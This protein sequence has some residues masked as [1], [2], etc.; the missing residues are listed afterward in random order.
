VI[1]PRTVHEKTE[2]LWRREI[3]AGKEHIVF[4]KSTEKRA[5]YQAFGLGAM[6][7]RH[8]GLGWHYEPMQEQTESTPAR[9]HG[10]SGH[11]LAEI[12]LTLISRLRGEDIRCL[13]GGLRWEEEVSSTSTGDQMKGAP[14]QRANSVLR[15]KVEWSSPLKR[16]GGHKSRAEMHSS[17]KSWRWSGRTPATHSSTN[18][19]L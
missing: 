7:P 14:A 15:G 5:Q 19:S 18:T 8:C 4:K 1:D 3:H 16:K 10:G 17:C 11:G 12:P 2:R 6:V 9:P 13:V